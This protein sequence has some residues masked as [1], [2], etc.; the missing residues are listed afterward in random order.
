LKEQD[1]RQAL[2][3]SESLR[4]VL[5]SPETVIPSTT[6]DFPQSQAS[7]VIGLS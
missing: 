2:G 4:S 1:Y 5:S 7:G 3:N 6:D